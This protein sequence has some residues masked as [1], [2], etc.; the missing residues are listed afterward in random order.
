MFDETTDD[1]ILAQHAVQHVEAFAILYRRYAN[2]VY[3]YLLS[4]VGNIEDAQDL[5]AQ[6]FLAALESLHTY[7]SEGRFSAWLLSIARHKAADH[8]RQHPSWVNAEVIEERLDTQLQP[9]AMVEQ[10]LEMQ[11]VF[12]ALSYLGPDRAEAL[13]LRVFGEL[14]MAEIATVMGKSEGA[15]KMLVARAFTDLRHILQSKQETFS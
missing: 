14:K 9:E 11:A 12:K 10:R 1:E 8:F 7:R 15:I 5:T 3:S 13:R 6:T 4:R 2:R